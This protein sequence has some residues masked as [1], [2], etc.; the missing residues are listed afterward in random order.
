MSQ[1]WGLSTNKSKRVACAVAPYAK[2]LNLCTGDA[3]GWGLGYYS[4]GELLAHITPREKGEPLDVDEVVH[5]LAADI[6]CMH[7]RM[8]TVGRQHTDN[9]HPFRFKDWLFA[10]NGT[11]A[12]FETFKEDMRNAMPPFVLRGI[13]GD[14][15]SQHLFH[16]FLSFL[17]DAGMLNRPNPGIVAIKEALGLTLAAVDEFA[18]NVGA[19]PSPSSL[20]VSDGY[21][22]VV[23]NRGIPVDYALIEGV[24]DCAMC[25]PSTIPGGDP[26]AHIDHP[27]LRAV[28]VRSGDLDG[29]SEPGGFL[30]LPEESCLMVRSDHTIEISALP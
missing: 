8:A 18:R 15:D 25:R 2:Q 22:L 10:H 21:S 28:L 19:H 7:T 12:A 6:L 14:S 4:R 30:S 1:F 5:D 3:G 11:L 16:L 26:G 20:I 17:Y 29:C 13:K 9:I 27:D 24:P 23:L